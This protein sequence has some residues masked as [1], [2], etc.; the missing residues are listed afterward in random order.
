MINGNKE[1]DFALQQV[2]SQKIQS[3]LFSADLSILSF[4][5]VK[6]LEDEND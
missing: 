6:L 2:V 1:N 4:I 5:D 3:F